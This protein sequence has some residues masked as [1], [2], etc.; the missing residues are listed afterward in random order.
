MS[1]VSPSKQQQQR[2]EAAVA[3]LDRLAAL[4]ATWRPNGDAFLIVDDREAWERTALEAEAAV[5]LVLDG[6]HAGTL[7]DAAETC[8]RR[9]EEVLAPEPL[10][11]AD[12]PERIHKA[13]TALGIAGEVLRPP[14]AQVSLRRV[15]KIA[16]RRLDNLTRTC[17]DRNVRMARCHGE[18]YADPQQLA[19]ACILEVEQIERFSL[20]TTSNHLRSQAM[21]RDGLTPRHDG[22]DAPTELAGANPSPPGR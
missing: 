9:V 1:P 4:V 18:V 12:T 13:R 2:T 15:A 19:A 11:H 3:C 7:R 6:L 16:S 17:R 8:R 14:W 10:I 5:D 22:A 21:A 20:R